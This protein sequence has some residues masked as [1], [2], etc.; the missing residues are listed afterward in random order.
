MKPLLNSAQRKFKNFIRSHSPTSS[1]LQLH[2]QADRSPTPTHT[3]H[4]S[5]SDNSYNRSKTVTPTTL[6]GTHTD[7]PDI[8]DDIDDKKLVPTI[9]VEECPSPTPLAPIST[10][11]KKFVQVKTANAQHDLVVLHAAYIIQKSSHLQSLILEIVKLSK[12][13]DVR[14]SSSSGCSFA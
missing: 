6:L 13:H 14:E 10:P 12:R 8:N 7:A 11:S 5:T 3:L 9:T 1:D 2:R 4:A